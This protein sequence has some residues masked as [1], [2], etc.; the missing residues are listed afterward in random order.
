MIVAR[1]LGILICLLYC[2]VTFAEL[3]LV[4]TLFRHGNRM[5][6]KHSFYP[7]DPHIN[8]NY[9][10][11]GQGGLTN[12]GKMSSYKL[13]Q[14]FRERYDHFLDRIYTKKD[15]WFRADE[16]DRIVMTGQL[17]A[18][19]LYPPFEEQ[20]WNTDLNWQPIPVWAPP[21]LTDHL[22]NG[23]HCENYKKWRD[24]VEKM[25]TGVTKF[26]KENKHVYKYLSEHTGGNITQ[27]NVFDLRSFLYAQQDIGLELPEWTKS[28]FP[29]G[30]LDELAAYDIHIRTRTT[31]LKQLFG[32]VWIQE[33]LNHIDNHI[34][35]NDTRKALMYAGH[36][37]NIAVIL[38]TLDNFDNKIP[39]YSSSLML[40]LHKE[41]NEYYIQ[42]FY[43]NEGNVR[44]LK[45]P[46]C[47]DK[48]CPLD[49]FKKIVKPII[50][51][52]PTAMC[53]KYI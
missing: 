41:N 10:P 5:P 31:Q 44:N 27:S 11:E 22:F 32:G 8:H 20:R 3:E 15:V 33:W 17:V 37:L 50:P 45:F 25:D 46:G 6:V 16:I 39:S 26:E 28:V 19:G 12:V 9:E 13:G 38:A 53:G 42:M 48:M 18:A 24:D 52:N 7:K 4:Q 43:R 40:E 21:I 49:V 30:K 34:N 23:I 36:E 47:E 51:A 14:Y 2:Q 1:A 29:H 35:K